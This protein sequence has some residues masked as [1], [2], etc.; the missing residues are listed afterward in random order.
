MLHTIKT[1][2]FL[3]SDLNTVWD[4]MRSPG[5]L[6]KI[7]PSYMG[8][9]IISDRKEIETM[10]PG[11]IIEYYVTPVLGLK[12]HWVTEIT[13]VEHL[14]YFVDEQRFGPYKLWHHK[15]FLKEVSGG[16]EMIDIVHYKIPFG[17]IGKIA[18]TLF[19]KNKLKEIFDYRFKKLEE[20]FNH[21]K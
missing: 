13:H 10:Y 4:F 2:Q 20:L 12:M 16:V 17:F 19:I 1:T 21:G 5:N 7:T 18:N 14:K 9:N 8:F 3:K 15:H 6:E 11:Q